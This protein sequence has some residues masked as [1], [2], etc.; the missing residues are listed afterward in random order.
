MS[1]RRRN[2]GTDRASSSVVANFESGLMTVAIELEPQQDNTSTIYRVEVPRAVLQHKIEAKQVADPLVVGHSGQL[3]VKE[4]LYIVMISVNEEATTSK[5]RSP[6]L[7]N[8][9]QA[10]EFAFKCR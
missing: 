8:L 1:S 5:I 2:E 6:V 3:L 7:Y 4:K 10:N 9:Y